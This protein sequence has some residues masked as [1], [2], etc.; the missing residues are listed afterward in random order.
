MKLVLVQP[1][2]SPRT[3]A[4]PFGAVQAQ[5]DRSRPSLGRSDVVLLPEGVHLDG[6]PGRYEDRLARLAQALGCHV[7]G[8][9]RLE[10]VCD[11]AVNSGLVCG[12]AGETIARYEKR[13][14][15]AGER[16]RVRPGSGPCVVRIADRVV[17]VTVC[18]DFWFFHLVRSGRRSPD[19]I[20]VAACSVSRKPTPSYAR[21]LWRHL[22][23]SR[24]YEIGAYVGI[25]DWHPGRGRSEF[26]ASGVAG[27][28]DPTAHD[29]RCLFRPLGEAG[30]ACFQ[31]D[32]GALDAFRKDRATRGFPAARYSRVRSLCR[33]P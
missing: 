28:A 7:V 18:A 11:G 2:P 16:S 30:I 4:D 8:G 5:I 32:F 14:P 19:L 12:P 33:A 13:N 3:L 1:R 20:L 26:S 25:S 23:V 10:R 31:I 27:L 9:S 6:A 29:P 24:A 21:A 17:L 15:Y 22:A